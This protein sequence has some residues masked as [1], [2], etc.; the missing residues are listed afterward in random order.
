[1]EG[2]KNIV[3]NLKEISKTDNVSL[4]NFAG[5]I[6]SLLISIQNLNRDSLNKI[7]NDLKDLI[8]DL[9]PMKSALISV[10]CGALVERGAKPMIL[11]EVLFKKVT[12]LLSLSMNFNDACYEAGVRDSNDPYSVI[13]RV[14]KD[15]PLE[16]EAWDAFERIYPAVVAVLSK[17]KDARK[18]VK[19]YNELVDITYKLSGNNRGA[20]WLAKIISVLD[21]EELLILYPSH[22]LGYRIKISGISNNHQLHLLLAGTLIGDEK[23][24]WIPGNPPDSKLVSYVRDVYY[25]GDAH[26]EGYF[27]MFNWRALK[28]D[29]TLVKLFET[30][31]NVRFDYYVIWGEE[32]PIT[33][34]KFDDTRIILLSPPSSEKINIKRS[35]NARREFPF[36]DAELQVL[37]KLSLQKVRDFITKIKRINSS[38]KE[39]PFVSRETQD[40]DKEYIKKELESGNIQV[41]LEDEGKLKRVNTMTCSNCGFK[42]KIG[43]KFCNECGTKF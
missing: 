35:F 9:N 30:Y 36:M 19:T 10:A 16:A 42:N 41:F 43:N 15:M 1:M 32:P 4:Q 17:S 39:N 12:N 24:G 33:I 20:Q 6:Q 40:R 34:P 11:A 14:K 27:Q 2:I 29:G 25:I 38:N 18:N 23:E 31:N 37:E 22:E 5:E 3:E 26:A 28:P 13:N 7:L 8:L 21:D